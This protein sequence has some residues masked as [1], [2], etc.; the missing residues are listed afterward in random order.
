MRLYAVNETRDDDILL[1]RT[2]S[3]YILDILTKCIQRVED[4]GVL[5]I[6]NPEL[7]RSVTTTE[8]TEQCHTYQTRQG[9]R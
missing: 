5:N 4:E 1:I 7:A 3:R 8:M 2:K 6:K 9:R